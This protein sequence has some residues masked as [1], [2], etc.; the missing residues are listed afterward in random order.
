VGRPQGSA[1][2]SVSNYAVNHDVPVIADGGIKNT[3]NMIKAFA[4]G[5]STVMMGSLLAGTEEAPGD[6]FYQDGVKLKCYRGMGSLDAMNDGS[7]QRYFA[8][9]QRVIVAQGV[10][11]TVGDR[12]SLSNLIPYLIQGVKH[13]FQ[14]IG[15]Q[16]LE[17][18]NEA[19]Y[20]GDLRLEIRTASA[21]KEG[22]IHSLHS[23]QRNKIGL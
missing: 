10:S 8:E 9:T 18:L 21:Q 6:Y 4:L 23:Y 19:R 11:G 5:A 16:N 15:A 2:Y 1:V 17:E 12:G 3:G 22:N 20:T 14:D 13:G 7:S